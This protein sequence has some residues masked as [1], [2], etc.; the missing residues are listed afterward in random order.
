MVQ[1]EIKFM[2]AVSYCHSSGEQITFENETYVYVY[3][4][5]IV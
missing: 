4:G 3:V 2:D 5:R 1:N